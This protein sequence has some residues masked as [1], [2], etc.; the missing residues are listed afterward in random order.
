MPRTYVDQKMLVETVSP[1]ELLAAVFALVDLGVFM[2][3]SVVVQTVLCHETL[4]THAAQVGV[5][6]RVI[7]LGIILYH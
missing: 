4:A 6:L 3:Q 1:A 2:A 5:T 7:D